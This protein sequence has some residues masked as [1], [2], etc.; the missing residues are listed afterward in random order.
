MAKICI[1][2]IRT[3][4]A[5]HPQTD[6]LSDL[7]DTQLLNRLA[8]IAHRRLALWPGGLARH[9]VGDLLRNLA[10]LRPGP[11]SVV[12]TYLFENLDLSPATDDAL[13]PENDRAAPISP[14]T[15]DPTPPTAAIDA[16]APETAIGPQR[17][18]KRPPDLFDRVLDWI[19]ALMG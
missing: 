15:T 7:D 3:V 13:G 6:S 16:P 19:A 18:R 12:L 10:H 8:K 9:R 2:E 14:P 4:L 17:F 1:Q 5:H 11:R